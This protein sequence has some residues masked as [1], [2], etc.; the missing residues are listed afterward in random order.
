M[1]IATPQNGSPV[2]HTI[3]AKPPQ[4]LAGIVFTVLPMIF[5]FDAVFWLRSA[6][7]FLATKARFSFILRPKI[8]GFSLGTAL[9]FALRCKTNLIAL[10]ALPVQTSTVDVRR[11]QH[12]RSP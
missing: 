12:F 5:A 9:L 3:P 6:N 10:F 11:R 7:P 2:E 4:A 8:C 1:P